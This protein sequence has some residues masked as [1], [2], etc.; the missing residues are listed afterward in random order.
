MNGHETLRSFDLAAWTVFSLLEFV[1]K[2]SRALE[3][4]AAEGTVESL[5][6]RYSIKHPGVEFLYDP[7]GIGCHLC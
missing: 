7:V 4:A 6:H 5:Q 3:E 1:K 2:T